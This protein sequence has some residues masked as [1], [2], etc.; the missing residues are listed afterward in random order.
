MISTLNEGYFNLASAAYKE[1]R[2]HK[3][4]IKSCCDN[5]DMKIAQQEL[6]LAKWISKQCEEG[7]TDSQIRYLSFLPIYVNGSATTGDADEYY[8]YSGATSGSN[9][10]GVYRYSGDGEQSI[11]EVNVNGAITKINLNSLINIDNAGPDK[12][13]HS[14]TEPSTLWVIVHNMGFVPGNELTTNLDGN[15]IEGVTRVID[16]NTI[17][18]QFSEPVAG[19][20]YLS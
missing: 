3:F 18:I 9:V 17:E 2:E 16:N 15:E 8:K 20:A 11:I 12:Y 6:D 1:T 13:T 7:L 5:S 10:A 14:Q 19:Y 4:G